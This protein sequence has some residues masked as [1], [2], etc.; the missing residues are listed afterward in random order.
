MG[1]ITRGPSHRNTARSEAPA[2][3]CVGV[4]AAWDALNERQRLYLSAIYDADQVAEQR[5]ADQR[6]RWAKP[7][8][9][10]DGRPIAVTGGD[11]G[12]VRV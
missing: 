6:R 11:D 4:R 5:V 7:L 9:L 3:Y 8:L 12:T 10:P 1:R 2:A